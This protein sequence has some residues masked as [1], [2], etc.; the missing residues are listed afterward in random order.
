MKRR[1]FLYVEDNSK[2]NKPDRILAVDETGAHRFSAEVANDGTD[3][4]EE[5]GTKDS[6]SAGAAA[7][8]AFERFCKEEC[9]LKDCNDEV[10]QAK[11]APLC[12]YTFAEYV[13]LRLGSADW[14]TVKSLSFD[15]RYETTHLENPPAFS[16]FASCV[17]G[18]AEPDATR[19]LYEEYAKRIHKEIYTAEEIDRM[20]RYIFSH[21]NTVYLRRGSFRVHWCICYSC[22]AIYKSDAAR[23]LGVM[24]RIISDYLKR[25]AKN[26]KK[27][28]C[29]LIMD[30]A[31]EIFCDGE[32]DYSVFDK[33]EGKPLLERTEYA[34]F[35]SLSPKSLK[36][37][38]ELIEEY[39]NSEKN[40]LESFNS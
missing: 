16:A 40:F 33:E 29:D 30:I 9:G 12:R 36:I 27:Y 23:Y 6:D 35:A 24:E 28:F 17:K 10:I 11:E 32:I 21:L 3:Y 8:A 26:R 38:K 4:R 37:V 18:V 14:A 34:M 2:K 25:R 20:E 39:E 1:V 15:Y 5:I 19:L 31:D 22:S 7:F 13:D